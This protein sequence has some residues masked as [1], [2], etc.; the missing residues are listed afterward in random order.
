MQTKEMCAAQLTE[1]G[2]LKDGH[3]VYHIIS[4]VKGGVD[5]PNNYCM[6]P[7]YFPS[8]YH[9]GEAKA[10]LHHILVWELLPEADVKC[11]LVTSLG[12][13]L[14]AGRLEELKE[15]VKKFKKDATGCGY[16]RKPR[17]AA[18]QANGSEA[19]G[20]PPA[21]DQEASQAGPSNATQDGS[22]AGPS[23]DAR[24]GKRARTEEEEEGEAAGC[25][26]H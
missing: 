17:R 4:P 25:R 8:D 18:A 1:W 5:H 14:A 9:L 16:T 12:E 6:L 13:E 10:K 22:Q 21:A 3:T 15:L 23:T 26:Q 7:N 24:S 19:Q 11:A 2:R 20:A